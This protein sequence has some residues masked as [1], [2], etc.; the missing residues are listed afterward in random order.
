MQ[1]LKQD[2]KTPA[3]DQPGLLAPD[4]T[5]MNFYRADPAEARHYHLVIDTTAI[6]WAAAADL[7]V[8]AARARGL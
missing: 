8:A 4:T 5:G 3:G 6:S 1:P 7:V 2:R